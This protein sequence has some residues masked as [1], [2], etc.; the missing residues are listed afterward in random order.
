M[1]TILIVPLLLTGLCL[2]AGLSEAAKHS[3]RESHAGMK[4]KQCHVGQKMPKQPGNIQC[5]PCHTPEEVID[6]SEYL[7]KKTVHTSPHWGTSTPCWVCHKEHKPDVN[8]CA[9]CH[10]Q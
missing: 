7:G 9:A 5:T 1:K 8:Y 6:L 3:L 4:C 2:G 10:Q